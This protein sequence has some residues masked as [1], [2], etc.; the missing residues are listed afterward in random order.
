MLDG[1]TIGVRECTPDNGE[2]KPR[3]PRQSQP[4]AEKNSHMT[5]DEEPKKEEEKPAEEKPAEEP[6][7]EEKEEEEKPAEEEKKEKKE[8]KEDNVNA[9]DKDWKCGS[10]ASHKACNA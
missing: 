9:L 7:E 3:A 8:K 5:F 2:R 6:K 10:V 4:A 1:R